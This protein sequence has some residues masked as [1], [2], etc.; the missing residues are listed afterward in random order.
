MKGEGG[1]EGEKNRSGLR[2]QDFKTFD[3]QDFNIS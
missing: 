1:L 2:A 3:F